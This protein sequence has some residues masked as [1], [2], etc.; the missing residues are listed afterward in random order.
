[1]SRCVITTTTDVAMDGSLDTTLID[2][3]DAYGSLLMSREYGDEGELSSTRTNRY[4]GIR[5]ELS[6]VEFAD[7]RQQDYEEQ[8]EYDSG[9]RLVR[10]I[11]DRGLDGRHDE[12]YDYSYDASDRLV[13]ATWDKNADSIVDH[14]IAY[15]YDELHRLSRY[16]VD[17]D[18]DEVQDY[19]V[20]HVYDGPCLIRVDTNFRN[21]TRE[22]TRFGTRPDCIIEREEGLIDDSV[23]SIGTYEYDATSRLVHELHFRPP[24]ALHEELKYQYDAEGRLIQVVYTSPT[25]SYL[26]AISN[27]C[28]AN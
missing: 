27:D 17:I 21:G 28:A 16:H 13:R 6:R 24:D 5:L 4:I 26:Q 20:Q 9:N 14:S 25:F 10:L 15:T 2:V 18:G 12:Y 11:V 7:G 3:Y 19:E 8:Y 1:M 22:S 23:E